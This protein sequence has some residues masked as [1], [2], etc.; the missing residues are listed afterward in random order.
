MS[1]DLRLR[2]E[3]MS[4]TRDARLSEDFVLTLPMSEFRRWLAASHASASLRAHFAKTAQER[5][6]DE[7]EADVKRRR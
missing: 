6:R 1:S 4:L 5:A 3:V 2:M 7:A